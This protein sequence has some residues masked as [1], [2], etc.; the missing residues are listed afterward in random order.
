MQLRD[1]V[2]EAMECE[3]IK[4]SVNEIHKI[5]NTVKINFNN[6]ISNSQSGFVMPPDKEVKQREEIKDLVLE[7]MNLKGI[8]PNF[9]EFVK[10]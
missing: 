6:P 4:G 7:K 2:Q 10:V 1:A 5:Q 9:T 3:A 8:T